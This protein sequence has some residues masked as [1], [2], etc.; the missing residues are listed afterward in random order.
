[1]IPLLTS[2][3]FSLTLPSVFG[4]KAVIILNVVDFPEPLGPKSPKISSFFTPKLLLVI[5]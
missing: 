3:F 2:I 1:M 5:A 4:V